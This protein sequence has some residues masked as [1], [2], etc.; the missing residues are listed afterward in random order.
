MDRASADG[1]AAAGTYFAHVYAFAWATG[2]LSLWSTMS[3]PAC[4]LCTRVA[5]DI[6]AMKEV[7]N[8]STSAAIDVLRA[9]GTEIDA[10]R[11]YSADL[12]IVQ[13]PSQVKGP[14]GKI[15][16]DNG[17]GPARL[18]IALAWLDDHWQVEAADFLPSE[19]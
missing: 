13:G 11:W 6:T 17:G 5:D 3:G 16:S 18:F 4:D 7:G 10:G 8:Y 14:D 2:D 12:E 1:A 15:V 9:D 19:L